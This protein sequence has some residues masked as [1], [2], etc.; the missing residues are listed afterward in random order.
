[1]Q[2][3]DN[4]VLISTVHAVKGLEFKVV[5]IVALEDGIFPIIRTGDRPSDMEEE[6]RL[7]YVAVTRAKERLFL[8]MSR[9]RYLYN[10]RKYQEMSQFLKEMGY[11]DNNYGFNASSF[12]YHRA[13]ADMYVTHSPEQEMQSIQ[14]MIAPKV[15][16]QETKDLSAFTVGTRVVHPKFGSGVVIDNRNINSNKTITINFD[17]V[18]NKT[19]SLDY[20]PLQIIKK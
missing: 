20:A 19:L 14:E 11:E 6:R 3:D 12:T 15:K 16:A 2:D 17:I 9:E 5:F 4:S 1:M 10:Q 18:G 7:M 13:N 8:T